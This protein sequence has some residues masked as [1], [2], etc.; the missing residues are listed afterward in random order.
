MCWQHRVLLAIAFCFL[1]SSSVQPAMAPKLARSRTPRVPRR[2]RIMDYY[3]A[4]EYQQLLQLDWVSRHVRMIELRWC[5]PNMY[6]ALVT[7]FMSPADCKFGMATG[8]DP[9]PRGAIALHYIVPA[10]RP[11]LTLC[12]IFNRA[13]RCTH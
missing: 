8:R 13:C 12:R 2:L 7:T 9:P 3:A 11:P 1:Q 4:T 6:H 10:A 5:D